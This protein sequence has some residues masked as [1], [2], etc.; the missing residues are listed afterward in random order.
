MPF[1]IPL[2]FLL[3]LF[4]AALTFGTAASVP[5][6]RR[7]A[8]TAPVFVFVAAPMT[9]L[10]VVVAFAQIKGKPRLGFDCPIALIIFLLAVISILA[11][12][13]VGLTCRF[14]FRTI[15]PRLEQWLGL[16]PFL[17]L[18]GPYCAAAR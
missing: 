14:A 4:A 8:I 9:S 10:A 6:W 18:Q 2:L 3:D 13:V 17:M 11:A 7:S 5:M 16:R 15:A 1:A 12:Y